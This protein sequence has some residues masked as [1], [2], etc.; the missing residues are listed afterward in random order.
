[1]G[2][3]IGGNTEFLIEKG[4]TLETLSPDDFQKSIILKKFDHQIYN[5]APQK[6]HS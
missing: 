3:G 1:M 5:L 6:Y 4:Y 2:C